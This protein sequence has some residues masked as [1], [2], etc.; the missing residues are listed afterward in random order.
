VRWLPFRR[1]ALFSTRLHHLRHFFPSVFDVGFTSGRSASSLV[2]VRD[3][4]PSSLRAVVVGLFFP[5][6]GVKF[7]S[8]HRPFSRYRFF[9]HPLGLSACVSFLLSGKGEGRTCG[10][11][12]ASVLC[13]AGLPSSD[14]PAQHAAAR[15]LPLREALLGHLIRSW[16]FTEVRSACDSYSRRFSQQELLFHPRL[17]FLFRRPGVHPSCLPRL[18]RNCLAVPLF[19]AVSSP[20]G[21]A[22]RALDVRSSSCGR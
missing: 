22:A 4:L 5:L 15:F 11:F 9:L 3:H 2:A 17:K 13:P 18:V 1:P 19:L 14:A 8:G 20:A 6:T 7:F 10:P 16:I 12:L 21:R